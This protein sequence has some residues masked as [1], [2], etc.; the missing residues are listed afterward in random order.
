MMIK[1]AVVVAVLVVYWLGH[2]YFYP[3]TACWWCKGNPRHT[4]RRSWNI[5]CV[6]CGGSGTRHRLGAKLLG[7]GFGKF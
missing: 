6:A 7:R 1:L 4:S 5:H 2:S 3:H